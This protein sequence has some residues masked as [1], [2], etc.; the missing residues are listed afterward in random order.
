MDNTGKIIVGWGAGLFACLCALLIA[1][2]AP[3]LLVFALG[4]IAAAL[5]GILLFILPLS[6]LIDVTLITTFFITGTLLFF[7]GQTS[8]LWIPYG[9]ASAVSIYAAIVYFTKRRAAM[10][11]FP[12]FLIFLLLFFLVLFLSTIT[13]MPPL[14]Q[15]L[16]GF[17]IYGPTW[18]SIG[19]FA[20]I[21]ASKQFLPK[22]EKGVLLLLLAQIPIIILQQYMLLSVA[23]TSWDITTGTF[24]GSQTGGGANSTLLFMLIVATLVAIEMYQTRRLKGYLTLGV[25][26]VCFALLLMGE[27]KAVFIFLPAALFIQQIELVRKAPF[28]FAFT[29]LLTGIVLTAVYSYYKS[30]YWEQKATKSANVFS[31]SYDG[32]ERYFFNP[33]E[34]NFATGHIGRGLSLQLWMDDAQ[35]TARTRLIGYGAGASRSASGTLGAGEVGKRFPQFTVSTTAITQLLWETGILGTVFFTLTFISAILLALKF[36]R[37]STDPVE[38]ARMYTIAATLTVLLGTLPYT[39]DLVDHP[40]EQIVAAVLLGILLQRYAQAQTRTSRGRASVRLP[41]PRAT[42]ATAA[43][44][45][46]AE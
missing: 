10:P 6:R 38:R 35:A 23:G 24:G 1:V 16:V 3:D 40:H 28:K 2:T 29:T 32:I 14:G 27:V 41:A 33:D 13:H 22:L 20:Y 15:L 11:R 31:L 46:A 39:R 19:A 21:A 43:P 7:S 45:P 5:F 18:L 17:K 37:R 42:S 4:G 12:A 34:I 25:V 44:S 8:A 30:E 36:A 9:L 26:T